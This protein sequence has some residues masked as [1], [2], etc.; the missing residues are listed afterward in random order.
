MSFFPLIIFH[1]LL[2]N[3]GGEEQENKENKNIGIVTESFVEVGTMEEFHSNHSGNMKP[4]KILL[5]S[6]CHVGC[7][8]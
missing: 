2:K 6:R 1:P 8:F 5:T 3:G 7:P 4:Q